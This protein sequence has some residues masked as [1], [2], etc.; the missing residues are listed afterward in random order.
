MAHLMRQ[1]ARNLLGAL[2]L[3][4]KARKEHNMPAGKSEGIC[5]SQADNMQLEGAARITTALKPVE[6]VLQCG[7]TRLIGTGRSNRADHFDSL[8]AHPVGHV[9]RYKTRNCFRCAKLAEKQNG[10]CD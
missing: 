9:V 6:N 4:Y 1:H 5:D 7:I 10:A 3:F 2:C 8:S